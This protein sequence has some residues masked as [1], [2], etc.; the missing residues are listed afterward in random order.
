MQTKVSQ[1]RDPQKPRMMIVA[2]EKFIAAI[3]S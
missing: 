1:L 3:A 2:A